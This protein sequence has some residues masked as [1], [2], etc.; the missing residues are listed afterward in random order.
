MIPFLLLLQAATAAP[1]P[2]AVTTKS[3]AAFGSQSTMAA[4]ISTDGNAKLVLRCD[5]TTVK[6][7]SLQLFTKVELGGTP[8][9]VIVTPD[10]AAPLSAPW[11]FRPK[12]AVMSADDMV[13]AL[14]AALS[15]A[16][17][18]K[19]RTTTAAGEAVDLTFTGPA[20][21]PSIQQVLSACDYK[22]GELPVRAPAPAPTPGKTDK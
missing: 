20:G 8:R 16:Q 18:I 9:P 15:G 1:A 19:V 13:T 7:V 21:N 14:T 10:A 12:A 6:V 4:Q 2:W 3:D 5:V 11:D 17:T 22:L